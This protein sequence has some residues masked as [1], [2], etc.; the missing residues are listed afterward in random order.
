MQGGFSF[1][2]LSRWVPDARF[3][4][5]RCRLGLCLRSV[6]DASPLQPKHPV[7]KSRSEFKFSIRYTRK[8]LQEFA[9]GLMHFLYPSDPVEP[10][11]PDETFRDQINELR[12]FGLG[13]SIVCLEEL[14]E[15]AC[16]IRSPL[17]STSTVVYRGWMLE[18]AE[19]EKL[20]AL[21]Q[22]YQATPLISLE[23]YL[24]CHYLPNW[25]PFVSEFT[26]ETRVFA[27]DSDLAKE[28]GTLGWEKFFIKDYV[29][30]LKTSVGSVVSK[31]EDVSLVLAEMQKFRGTIEGGVCV[32][33]FE[34]FV[35]NSE[36]R[37]FVIKGKPYAASG[38]VP[39]LVSEC[40][41][42]INSP[43]FSVDVAMRADGV[44]RVVEIGDGQVS[45]LVGWEATRF[46]ELWKE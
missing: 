2:E 7:G 28:L 17:P 9:D 1:W 40:A 45:D 36:K 44:L 31:P 30:S 14:G 26:A 19:Y 3:R 34:E 32:R 13:V 25:Y 43:F 6:Q 33:R 21:I 23:T 38:L 27:A 11:R 35:P 29:K 24:A 18:P 12:S 20:V 8:L 41:Q 46:A 37:F 22:S 4:L 39:Q 16:R 10:K 42:R 5:S 15:K